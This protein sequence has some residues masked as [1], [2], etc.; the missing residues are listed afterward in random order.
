LNLNL[1]VTQAQARAESIL[2]LYETE[3]NNPTFIISE[4]HAA[5]KDSFI[6]E[7]EGILCGNSGFEK[8]PATNPKN[9]KSQEKLL[10]INLVS[11]AEL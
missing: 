5:I 4:L 1:I 2:D 9:P 11:R 8:K 10:P 7:V 3:A 6:G